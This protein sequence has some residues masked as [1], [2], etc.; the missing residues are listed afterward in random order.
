MPEP[1]PEKKAETRQAKVLSPKPYIP[2]QEA[3]RILL[4]RYMPAGVLVNNQLDII[5]FRGH[6]GAFL[7]PAA[8]RASLNLLGMVREGLW[9]DLRDAI[10]AARRQGTPVRRKSLVRNYAGLQNVILDVTPL[11][12]LTE[13]GKEP[14]F[15]IIFDALFSM[16][17]KNPV[18]PEPSGDPGVPKSTRRLQQENSELKEYIFSLQSESKHNSVALRSAQEEMQSS[19]EELQSMNE[20]LE[21]SKEELQSSNE[22]LITT[23]EELKEKNRDLLQINND[24]GNVLG[25][26]DLPLLILDK[27]L[28]IRKFTPST[29][30]I[31]SLISADIG[32]S[33][34][35]IKLKIAI[36]DLEKTAKLVI[37][38][39]QPQ[40][41]EIGDL[42][43][44]WYTLAVKPYLTAE[45]S[46]DGVLL[47]FVDVTR[48]KE[49]LIYSENIVATLREPVIV[50][51]TDLKVIS[52]NHAF[53]KTFLVTPTEVENQHLYSLNNHEWDIPQLRELLEKIIP[54]N[55][56]VVDFVITHTFSGL[57]E[58]TMLLNARRINP[59]SGKAVYTLLAIED[60]TDRYRREKE[61]K[62]VQDELV[63][64]NQR[65]DEFLSMLAH[66]LRNPLAP[67]WTSLELMKRDPA[68]KKEKILERIERIRRQVV[69]LTRIVDDLM[70]TSRISRGLISLKKE[71]VNFAE[72]VTQA[73]ETHQTHIE[74]KNQVLQVHL[75]TEPLE[76][77]ADPVRVVQIISN[78]L[79]NAS[80][81]TPEKGNI[82]VR[83]YWREHEAVV[84]VLDDGIGLSPEALPKVFNLFYQFEKG[85]DRMKG[86]LGI[87][88][89]LAKNLAV[90]HGGMVDVH[91]PGPGKGSVFT[92]RLPLPKKTPVTAAPA[93]LPAA[94][95][96]FRRSSKLKILIVEDNLEF[97][98]SMSEFLTLL[99]HKVWQTHNG[100]DAL[101]QANTVRP[102]VVLL[103]ISLPG[104]DGYEIAARLHANRHLS[105]TILVALTGYNPNPKMITQAGFRK[106]LTKPVDLGLLE[107]F[108]AGLRQP[109]P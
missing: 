13:P 84:E 105:R 77:F 104:M 108:L 67:I 14:F 56:S 52:A 3:D 75:P 81:Y 88:L 74:A 85:L 12:S 57:G 36:P 95:Q 10:E 30:S 8:G 96:A 6:T 33:V 21:T 66:E 23:N 83:A 41:M 31:F 79:D 28:K 35:D 19:N 9:N 72:L 5:Q 27:E 42:K 44:G 22:E 55:P 101:R 103:D 48:M 2:E 106:Y 51:D 43:N 37:K 59:A 68:P 97:A 32:R 62:E 78:L 61:L 40:T 70:D 99:E 73:V 39:L 38:T 53:Y 20:E 87:G 71:Q 47:T 102:D 63:Q 76:L 46:I 34:N 109:A 24:L 49:N 11:L 91:S 25:A 100:P 26:I 86:G 15:L 54:L 16:Q 94:V 93:V 90:L 89:T 1:I 58:K 4:N 45:M 29:K 69:Y 92:L 7:E 107:Q 64:A 82:E 18:A 65:K 98:D 60:I 80:K 17:G 50:L